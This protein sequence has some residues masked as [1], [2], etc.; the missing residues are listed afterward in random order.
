MN[1]NESYE[2]RF[3]LF[4]EYVNIQSCHWNYTMVKRLNTIILV[5]TLIP[6]TCTSIIK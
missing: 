6:L 5:D 2:V 1:S 4:N 3:K